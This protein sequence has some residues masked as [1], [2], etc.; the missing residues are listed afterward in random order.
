MKAVD[1]E[2]NQSYIMLVVTCTDQSTESMYIPMLHE[3]AM[4]GVDPNVTNYRG[5]SPLGKL[6]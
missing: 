3:L 4:A 5:Q 6:L 1:S 2:F